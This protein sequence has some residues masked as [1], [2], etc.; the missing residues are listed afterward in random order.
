MARFAAA[1]RALR[2]PFK[3]LI[4]KLA[5]TLK[6]PR[7]K[8]GE[9]SAAHRAPNAARRGPTARSLSADISRFTGGDVKRNKGGYT[10][11][12]PHGSRGI[13]VRVM[14]DGGDR[15]NYYRVSVPGKAAY[16]VTGDVSTDAGTTH[17]PIA[18]GALDQILAIITR[19]KG[20]S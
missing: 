13:T 5:L 1:S 9:P 17:I 15:T 8:R 16:S 18:D 2:G 11:T 10:V 19:I 20:G 12:I 14:E 6:R 3:K 4:H 7:M